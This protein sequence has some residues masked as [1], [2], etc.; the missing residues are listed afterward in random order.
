[1]LGR[2]QVSDSQMT[3]A[4]HYRA[5]YVEQGC[6]FKIGLTAKDR[7]FM[8][9]ETCS[10]TETYTKTETLLPC[11]AFFSVFFFMVI[12]ERTFNMHNFV[13]LL[14]RPSAPVI[15]FI[16]SPAMSYTILSNCSS[17]HTTVKSTSCTSLSCSTIS[18][19][20][21]TVYIFLISSFLICRKK[22]SRL[23]IKIF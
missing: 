23:G 6:R 3:A 22:N 16:I 12:A 5:L 14:Q 9:L 17:D 21:T 2:D 10:R 11:S 18:V 15:S 20:D 7:Q 13:C 8:A 4:S 19:S 1:M